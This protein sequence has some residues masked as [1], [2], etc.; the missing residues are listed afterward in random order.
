VQGKV[1]TWK[2]KKITLNPSEQFDAVFDIGD[3][4]SKVTIEVL[5]V[6]TPNN[7]AYAYWSNA[8]EVHLQSAKRSAWPHAID[9]VYWYP[10]FYGEDFDIVVEDGPW[11]FAGIPWTYQPM[12]PGL[13]KLTLIGDYSNEDPVSFKVKITRENERE[14]LDKKARISNG[15]IKYDTWIEVPVE[16]PEGTTTATFDLTWHREYNDFPTSDLDMYILGPE[17]NFDGATGNAPERAILVDP[18]PGT[19]LV[20]IYGYDVNKPDNYDLYLTL[21]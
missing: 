4:T 17:F 15:E 9:A 13:M 6:D 11:T 10:Y 20:L 5:N 16:I 7:Y 8:L 2:S 12:E 14:P 19:Y 18:I 21:E 3:A 1:Q